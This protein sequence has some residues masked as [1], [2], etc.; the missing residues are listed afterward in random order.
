MPFA[1]PYEYMYCRSSREAECA[2]IEGHESHEVR[3]R[4]EDSSVISKKL[5]FEYRYPLL[6]PKLLEF[7]VRLPTQ[8]KRYDGH[9]RYLIRQYLAKEIPGNIFQTYQKKQGLG[10]VPSTFDLFQ[11]NFDKGKYQQLFQDLPYPH[12]IKN[13]SEPIELRHTIKGF[14]LKVFMAENPIASD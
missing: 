6:Y 13:K 2:L 1:H 8:Q 3:M 4:I 9:G 7:M 12:L 5:G 14:M 11:T 10:I